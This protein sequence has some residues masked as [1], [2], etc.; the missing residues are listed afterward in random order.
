M[1]ESK[2][3]KKLH[4][5]SVTVGSIIVWASLNGQDIRAYPAERKTGGPCEYVDYIG[6][7]RI[8]RVERTIRSVRQVNALGGPRYEGYEIQFTF[9]TN[10]QI[11]ETW[12]KNYLVKEH[13]FQLI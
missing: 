9:S 11:K 1:K 13:L 6:E 10:E 2:I 7:S 4:L 12:A 8:I 3:M 5:I